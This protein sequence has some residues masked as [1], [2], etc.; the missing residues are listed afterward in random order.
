MKKNETK[1][2]GPERK[3]RRL[4]L[5]REVILVLAD[6]ALLARAQGGACDLG[7]HSAQTATFVEG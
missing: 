7:T 5:S 2:Q 1:D 6:P 4:R 3:P